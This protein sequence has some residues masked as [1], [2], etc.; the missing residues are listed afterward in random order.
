MEWKEQT[1]PEVWISG[2]EVEWGSKD[3]ERPFSVLDDVTASELLRDL[4][5]LRG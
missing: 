4:E 1:I 5:H 2:G 3:G